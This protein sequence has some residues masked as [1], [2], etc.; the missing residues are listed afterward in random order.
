[1]DCANATLCKNTQYVC[2]ISK[3]CFDKVED[4]VNCPKLK[5]THL[6]WNLTLEERVNYLVNTMTLDEK[7]LSNK[8]IKNKYEINIKTLLKY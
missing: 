6:D 4:Y 2:P 5:G 8:I 7:Q 3:Q 1:M